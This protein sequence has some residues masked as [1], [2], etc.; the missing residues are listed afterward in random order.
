VLHMLSY[1]YAKYMIRIEKGTNY[2]GVKNKLKGSNIKLPSEL[3]KFM[4]KFTLTSTFLVVITDCPQQNSKASKMK[5]TQLGALADP[6]LH[7]LTWYIPSRFFL[8]MFP[9]E[10]I[11]EL[12]AGKIHHYSI[13]KETRDK[14]QKPVMQS[15]KHEFRQIKLHSESPNRIYEVVLTSAK[16]KKIYINAKDK[17][18]YMKK[19]SEPWLSEKLSSL[20]NVSGS[21]GVTIGA[22]R[23]SVSC[24]CENATNFWYDPRNKNNHCVAGGIVNWLYAAGCH[25][26]ASL[27]KNWAESKNM[28]TS[29]E[30]DSIKEALLYMKEELHIGSA[31]INFHT[32]FLTLADTVSLFKSFPAPCNLIFSSLSSHQSHSLVVSA[33]VVYDLQD[34]CPYELTL[35]GLTRKL[36][37]DND[38]VTLVGAH[39]FFVHNSKKIQIPHCRIGPLVGDVDHIPYYRTLIRSLG[40]KKGKRKR[41][42]KKKKKK[43]K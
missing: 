35:S 11:D 3:E 16:K 34:S 6:L 14:F 17:V 41:R 20:C 39:Y 42:K 28:L 1:Y 31:K 24:Y 26:E 2:K 37:G 12:Y 15:L 8:T 30:G 29:D 4:T 21:F 7:K 22:G 5:S 36:N 23:K 18:D 9:K 25:S 13:C 40:T 43:N 27:L 38:V 19:I 33:K 32:D 10:V